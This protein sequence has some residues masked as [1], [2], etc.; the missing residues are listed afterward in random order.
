MVAAPA[1]NVRIAGTISAKGADAGQTGGKI[2][3][4][5][6]NI[7]LTPGTVVH[8]SEVFELIQYAPQTETVR[9]VPLL[10]APPTFNKFY[11]LD[12]APGRSMSLGLHIAIWNRGLEGARPTRYPGD[13]PKAQDRR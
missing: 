10:F 4:T 7:A 11:V 3:I 5:G 1:Q 12:L 8:H 6:E 9:E 2:K 13:V